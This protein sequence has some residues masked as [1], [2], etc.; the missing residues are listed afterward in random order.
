LKIAHD[1]LITVS[2]FGG[3]HLWLTTVPQ[4]P[5]LLFIGQISTG[6]SFSL[7][8][9]LHFLHYFG[10]VSRQQCIGGVAG[11]SLLGRFAAS[12]KRR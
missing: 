9:R 1:T 11:W 12:A 10:S 8:R 2:G 5:R 6:T 7:S 3:G 4:P